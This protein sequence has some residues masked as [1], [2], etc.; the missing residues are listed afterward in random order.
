LT[1]PGIR[2]I[3]AYLYG[4]YMR[5]TTFKLIALFFFSIGLIAYELFVMRVFSV[6]SWSNFGSMIISTALLGFG[7]AGTLLTFLHKKIKASPNKWL[8]VLAAAAMP[9]MVFCYIAAQQVPFNPMFMGADP[10]QVVWIGAF[11]LIYSIPFFLGALFIGISFIVLASRMYG[12]Y[13]WNMCGSGLG[14]LLIIVCMFFLPTSAL[15]IPILIMILAAAV[16]C[17]LRFD[18][19]SGKP[20]LKTLH[21]VS[22]GVIFVLC[23][24]VFLAAG[25]IRVSDFKPIFYAEHYKD[26]RVVS[27]IFS[28]AGEMYVFRSSYFHSAPGMSM[29]A[30]QKIGAAQRQ[31]FCGLYIDGNGPIVIMGKTVPGEQGFLEYLPT[32]APYVIKEKPRVL[33][34]NIGGSINCEVAKYYD[35]SSITVVEP[36]P[37]LI[38]M[39]RNDPFVA[40]FTGNRLND[41]RIHVV[42]GEPR[43]FCARNRGRFDIVEISLVDSVG[44][45]QSGGYAV[46]ENFTYTEQAIRDYLEGLDKDGIL[47]ITVWDRLKPPRNVLKILSTVVQSLSDL[48]VK[49]PGRHLF[50]FNYLNSTATVLVKKSPFLRDEHHNEVAELLAFTDKLSLSD[51]YYPGIAADGSD[52]P[53]LIDY[54]NSWFEEKRPAGADRPTYVEPAH[55]YRSALLAMLAGRAQEL[56]RDYIFDVRPMTDDRPYYTVYLKPSKLG[57]VLDQLPA[58]SEDW[59]YLLLLAVLIVSVVFAAFIVLIPLVGRWREL[60]SKKRGTLGVIAYYACLGLGYMLIEMFLIQRLVFFLSNP[61]VSVSIVIT[62]MLIISGIGSICS[63]YLART[64][65]MIVRLA[66]LGIVISVLFYLFGLSPVLSLFLGVPFGVKLALAVLLIAPAAF[67]LGMPFPNGLSALTE[68]RPRLL[69]W[70]WGMN[71]ALSVTGTV[72]GRLVS[73]SV[74]FTA[75]LLIAIA[76]YLAVGLLFPA[77]R[78][79]KASIPQK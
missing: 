74:G 43:A 50:V 8:T 5:S 64:K 57:W 20:F 62:A 47:S 25:S 42:V 44:L 29:N 46:Q 48:G 3:I 54:Y 7:V 19:E 39:Y 69:P 28:P 75:V 49:E 79:W 41:S 14:G 30:W 70:A 35:S 17:S 10:L 60:F 63:R 4:G 11:Y 61:I 68:T 53:R 38:N 13:F 67:F 2:D 23:L 71:G 59:G 51:I 6:G 24:G 9:A 26:S 45:S 12:L 78:E 18:A 21:L 52:L 40:P 15:L 76:A 31:S 22:M 36:N 72:L 34:V 27:R 1:N 77:N 55:F 37:E 32:S 16:L 33:L 65:V 56:Y 66:V 58:V 73:V